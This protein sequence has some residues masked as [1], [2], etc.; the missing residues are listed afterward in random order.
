MPRIRV[1]SA[2]DSNTP[3]SS[4]NATIA[5]ARDGPIPGSR[6]KRS[7]SARFTSMGNRSRTTTPS[8]SRAS[9]DCGGANTPHS[10]PSGTRQPRTTPA[11][12]N[13]RTFRSSRV[14]ALL[15]DNTGRELFFRID[16]CRSRLEA[17]RPG[18]C[19][20]VS[21]LPAFHSREAGHSGENASD[22]SMVQNRAGVRG[23][24]GDPSAPVHR[25]LD[26]HPDSGPGDRRGERRRYR[27][28]SCRSCRRLR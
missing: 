4:R 13:R 15:H 11:T 23:V 12:R 20:Q 28:R 27:R 8:S 22:G 24:P 9:P 7:A 18:L 16:R 10:P 25:R 2:S 6:S 14:I 1:S 17:D 19:L 21:F 26:A 3:R 5:R